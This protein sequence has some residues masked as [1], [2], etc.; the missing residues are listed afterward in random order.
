MRDRRYIRAGWLLDGSGG[1]VQKDVLLTVTDAVITALEPYSSAPP[2]ADPG[3][4]T[5][6]SFATLLPPLI[7]C[8]VHLC[9]SGTMDAKAREQQLAAG[10]AELETVIGQNLTL[11]A[12]HGVLAVRDGGDRGGCVSDYIKRHDY[13]SLPVLVQTPGRAWHRQGRYGGLIGANPAPGESLVAAYQRENISSTYLKLVNSG[14]NSLKEYGRETS[15]QFTAAEIRPLVEA[16]GRH[17]KK[18][19][20]MPMAV[21]LYV[22]R[23]WRV[24]TPSS[25]GFSWAGITWNAWPSVAVS[26]Y[27]PPVP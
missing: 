1:P 20:C 23:F 24:V 21:N 16:A 2:V 13:K 5:D 26:G 8:H 19:W 22:R 18:S 10:C 4:L 27:L 25:T 14:L 15:A 11:L 6:L 7:D 9:M 12:S 17:G 3:D